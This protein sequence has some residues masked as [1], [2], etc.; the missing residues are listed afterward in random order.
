MVDYPVVMCGPADGFI[1]CAVVLLLS[2]TV[3][4]VSTCDIGHYH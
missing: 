1:W 2:H 3:L 4:V